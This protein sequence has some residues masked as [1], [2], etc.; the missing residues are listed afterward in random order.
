MPKG[1]INRSRSLATDTVVRPRASPSRNAFRP[2]C[3]G[4]RSPAIFFAARREC[5]GLIDYGDKFHCCVYCNAIRFVTSCT[6][7]QIGE[8][9]C[10]TTDIRWL[11]RRANHLVVNTRR[12]TSQ[13]SPRSSLVRL[14]RSTRTSKPCWHNNRSSVA[15]VN[16]A[17][18][19]QIHSLRSRV[20][21]APGPFPFSYAGYTIGKSWPKQAE[22]RV[23][24]AR[25]RS[26]PFGRSVRSLRS[27]S[28]RRL[29]KVTLCSTRV[30][31]RQMAARACIT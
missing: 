4:T 11:G 16:V 7:A 30:R 15:L 25:R 21:Y 23:M 22:A 18:D 24:N 19:R 9:T 13:Y 3:I 8:G 2:W 31:Q 28:I 27:H 10:Q 17:P 5:A 14:R 12:L 26:W 1:S 29:P 6:C 20:A